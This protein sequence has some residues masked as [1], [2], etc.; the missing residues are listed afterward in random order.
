[1][2]DVPTRSNQSSAQRVLVMSGAGRDDAHSPLS[3]RHA[4]PA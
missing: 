1:M 2:L 3:G 4:I